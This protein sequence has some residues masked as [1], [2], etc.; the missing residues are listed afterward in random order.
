MF[1]AQPNSHALEACKMRLHC[2]AQHNTVLHAMAVPMHL[3]HAA[4]LLWI[5]KLGVSLLL[6]W[7]MCLAVPAVLPW[8]QAP[9]LCHCGGGVHVGQGGKLGE[10]DV[11][12]W[13]I[14]RW[15]CCKAGQAPWLGTSGL[16]QTDVGFILHC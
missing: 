15:G 7:G 5:V 11:V 13:W 2:S 3:L 16:Q 9:G 8:T 6:C 4:F 14:A 1:V 12:T 10:H